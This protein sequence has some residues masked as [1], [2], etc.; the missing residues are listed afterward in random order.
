V[1]EF[2]GTGTA[3]GLEVEID[4]G[5]EITEDEFSFNPIRLVEIKVIRDSD[6][7]NA[8]NDKATFTIPYELNGYK[9][10]RAEAA[11]KTVS[12]AGAISLMIRN[13]TTTNDMLSTAITIDQ[14]ELNSYTAATHSAVN[15][16]TNTVS[17]GNM[18]SVDVDSIGTGTKGLDITLTFKN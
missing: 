16:V 2:I 15:A 1:R 7:L 17:T 11:I 9:L 18:I 4:L 10:I 3:N 14:G 8:G 5:D 12:S 13:A 6:N